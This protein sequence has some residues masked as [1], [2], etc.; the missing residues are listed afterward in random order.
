VRAVPRCPNRDSR[1]YPTPVGTRQGEGPALEDGIAAGP[2]DLRDHAGAAF[3]DH[4]PTMVCDCLQVHSCHAVASEELISTLCL[5]S[6]KSRLWVTPSR[7][8]LDVVFCR[9]VA[10][11]F[12]GGSAQSAWGNCTW[13][14]LRIR[15]W[16]F[17][18][19]FDPKRRGVSRQNVMVSNLTTSG[20]AEEEGRHT[21][22][23]EACPA[24]G[25][26]MSS[27]YQTTWRIRRSSS[28]QVR[29][30]PPPLWYP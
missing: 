20:R 23:C 14:P 8:H 16:F 5:D 4:Q 18:Q 9:L 2:V 26:S 1:D 25:R 22:A 28:G 7:R 24:D 11:G 19:L 21:C 3:V 12:D 6:A 17:P 13:Y 10:S 29:G 15:V 27:R 30:G